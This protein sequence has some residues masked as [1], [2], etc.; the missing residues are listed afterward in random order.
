MRRALLAIALLALVAV[1][2]S[3][4]I[5]TAAPAGWIRFCMSNPWFCQQHGRATVLDGQ[6]ARTILQTVNQA[7][8]TDIVP[9][10]LNTPDARRAETRNWRVVMPGDPGDCVEYALFKE[11]FLI[12][13]GIPREALTL[14]VVHRRSQSHGPAGPRERDQSRS[15]QSHTHDLARRSGAMGLAR[16]PGP[17]LQRHGVGQA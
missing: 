8:N 14:A 9:A 4:E 10:P 11:A 15:R 2:A 16:S 13:A 3:A 1:P 6:E 5:P 7:I 17:K 12:W